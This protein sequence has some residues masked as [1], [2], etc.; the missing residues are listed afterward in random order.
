LQ[1]VCANTAVKTDMLLLMGKICSLQN[2]PNFFE[3]HT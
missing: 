2:V 1:D 3:V